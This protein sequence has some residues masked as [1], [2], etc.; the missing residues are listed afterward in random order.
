MNTNELSQVAFTALWLRNATKMGWCQHCRWS[1]TLE[2]HLKTKDRKVIRKV[3]SQL[4]SQGY[5]LSLRI[6]NGHHPHYLFTPEP[7]ID[8]EMKERA[9]KYWRWYDNYRQGWKP[10]WGN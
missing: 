6:A 9:I 1:R 5:F 7:I 8:D 2:Y 4:L 10:D 3:F